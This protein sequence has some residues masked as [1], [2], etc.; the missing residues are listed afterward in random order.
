MLLPTDKQ[1]DDAYD[2]LRSPT[3]ELDE[4]EPCDGANRFC[5]NG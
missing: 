4:R 3:D 2:P 1:F 5:V